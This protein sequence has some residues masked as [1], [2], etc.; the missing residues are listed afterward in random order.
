MNSK[1]KECIEMLVSN[2][3]DDLDSFM[4]HIRDHTLIL[5]KRLWENPDIPYTYGELYLTV[6]VICTKYNIAHDYEEFTFSM[7]DIEII[8]K[9]DKNRLK[10]MELNILRIVNWHPFDISCMYA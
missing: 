10:E 5:C 9:I 7:Q 1:T 6:L 3:V 2:Q 4:T 8:N